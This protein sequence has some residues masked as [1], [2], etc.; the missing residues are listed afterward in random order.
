MRPLNRPVNTG[1]AF[2]VV[3]PTDKSVSTRTRHFI[4]WLLEISDQPG[5]FF[6]RP[7][8]QAAPAAAAAG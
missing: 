4:D 5:A 3:W 6:N 7:G 1:G 8:R 2:H